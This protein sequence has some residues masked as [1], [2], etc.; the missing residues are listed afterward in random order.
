M[1][2]E[3][4]KNTIFENIETSN[5]LF[6]KHYHDTY[7][8]GITHGGLF[9]S[10]NLNKKI[11][12]YKNST[13]IVNPYDV[14]HGDSQ[15]WSY[16]NFYPSIELM[17]SVYKQMY[18]VRKTPLF[19]KHI[20]EDLTLYNYLYTMFFS[21]YKKQ[22]SMIIETNLIS[23]LSY[24]IKNY[25]NATKDYKISFNEKSIISTSLEYINDTISENTTL[26]TLANVSNLSK[27]H[28][29]RVFKE[30]TGL[31]PHHYILTLKVQKARDMIIKGNSLS[32]TSYEL[33]FSDQSHFIRNFRKIYGYSP[34]KLFEKSNFILYK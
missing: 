31:T 19:N 8:I 16:T 21:I 14:H 1:K 33:G 18:N 34:K 11:N 24:L 3:T 4:L 15:S 5:G 7:T 27:Y 26:D 22:D 9:K 13:R 28:F 23:A 29:L 10:I 25:T 6:T 20:L 17:S 12:S 30:H 2:I 32:S